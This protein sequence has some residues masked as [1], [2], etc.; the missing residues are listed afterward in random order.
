MEQINV[1]LYWS[2]KMAN[3]GAGRKESLL[4]SPPINY[5]REIHRKF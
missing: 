3:L 4:G 1:L 2:Y 5:F